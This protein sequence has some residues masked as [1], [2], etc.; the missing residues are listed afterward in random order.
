MKHYIIVKWNESVNDKA[1]L[2]EEVRALY[3]SADRID[4]VDGAEVIPNCIARD[5]RYD[6]MIVV[7]MAKEALPTWDA[8]DLHHTWKTTY[9]DRI[10]KKAIFDGE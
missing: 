5:N 3:Q 8:S 1:S 9:G 2:A 10:E 6:L 7:R 4:G